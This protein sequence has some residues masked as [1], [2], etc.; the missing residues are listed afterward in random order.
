MLNFR[1]AMKDVLFVCEIA[2]RTW[3]HV[4]LLGRDNFVISFSSP[5]YYRECNRLVRKYWNEESEQNMRAQ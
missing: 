2:L 1:N 4:R 3:R 5:L